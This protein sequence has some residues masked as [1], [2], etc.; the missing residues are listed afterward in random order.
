M[1]QTALNSIPDGWRF[2]L[3]SDSGGSRGR[4]DAHDE[5][6]TGVT[7][8]EHYRSYHYRSI[9]ELSLQIHTGVIT[10]DPYR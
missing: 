1:E 8:R 5:L 9:P 3:E 4:Y 6:D 2:D 10:T 7:P